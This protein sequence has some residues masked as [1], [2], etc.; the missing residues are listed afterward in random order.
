MDAKFLICKHCGHSGEDVKLTNSYIG[1]QGYV[2]I[3]LC[4]D[5]KACWQRHD[6]NKKIVYA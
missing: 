1:G 5:R 6:A 4:I 3:P 2:L